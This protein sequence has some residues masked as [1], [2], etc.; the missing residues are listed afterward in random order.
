MKRTPHRTYYTR[1]LPHY[2]PVDATFSVAFRL[3]GSLPVQVT[4]MMKQERKTAERRFA[5]IRNLQKR[6]AEYHEYQRQYFEKF[7]SLLD[8]T[9]AG[10]RWLADDRIAAIVS[11]SL[12]FL[13]QVRWD[14]FCFCIM[15]NHVHLVCAMLPAA[16]Q[17]RAKLLA[18][19]AETMRQG[20][21]SL[22]NGGWN[23][24]ILTDQLQSTKKFSARKSNVVLGRSGAFWHRE[25]YDHVIRNGEELERTL[26]YIVNNPV[27][28]GLAATWKDWKWT[29]VKEGLLDR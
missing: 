25:S 10:P 1:N 19:D 8:G 28:A 3:A 5:G 24:G 14:L 9:T 11:D 29:Y 12:H 22:G 6:Y 4:A 21:D 26:W 23:H 18:N 20:H 16:V 2:Q 15:P 17:G 7:D 27:K 13:D